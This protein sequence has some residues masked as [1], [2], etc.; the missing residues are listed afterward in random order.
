MKMTPPQPSPAVAATTT[1]QDIS[2]LLM[3]MTAISASTLV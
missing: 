2:I 1:I 3:K